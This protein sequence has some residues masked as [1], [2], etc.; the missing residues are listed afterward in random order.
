MRFW[1]KLSRRSRGELDDFGDA[2]RGELS[3]SPVPP[4]SDELLA[5]ILESRRRGVR[6]ILP[7]NDGRPRRRT[8]LHASAV[9]A[10]AVVVMATQLVRARHQG[11]ER[12]DDSWFVSAHAYARAARPAGRS[13][14]P[15]LATYAD[16]LHPMELRYAR[17]WLDRAGAVRDR[18]DVRVAVARDV[19][20]GTPAWRVITTTTDSAGVGL[21]SAWV[22]TGDLTLLRR[23]AVR[24]P[25]RR[26]DRIIV[27]QLFDGMRLTGEMT[28]L[29]H[30]SVDA[31]RTFDR[32]LPSGFAPYLSDGFAPIRHMAMPLHRE[33]TGSVSVLGWAVRDNDVFV[34][35]D[36]RVDGEETIR[37][38]A[39]EFACWRIEVRYRGRRQ[40]YWA[41][42]TDGLGVRALDSTDV[43]TL[44]IRETLLA[45]E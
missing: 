17:R 15:A 44:G 38:P 31:R 12:A 4:A 7:V 43:A 13:Y 45:A 33:W 24:T 27:R 19:A 30:G 18:A 39:G 6:L 23:T 26:Y 25:Y 2:I 40:W 32:E 9:A 35:V 8:L 20:G 41:R 5:R 34:P 10:A 3:E 22:R 42:K 28:A 16:R 1:S 21:D 11:D 36:L 37:V 29:L 14:A